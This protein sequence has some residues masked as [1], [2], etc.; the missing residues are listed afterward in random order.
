MKV[1][2]AIHASVPAQLSPTAQALLEPVPGNAPG[3]P[4]LED[5]PAFMALGTDAQ[6]RPERCIGDDTIPAETPNWIDIQTRAEAL[7]A[8]SKDVRIALIWL[9]AVT[10]LEG[11]EGYEAGLTFVRELAV[12]FWDTLHPRLEPSASE[13]GGFDASYRQNMFAELAGP[14]LM[15]A[16]RDMP[17]VRKRG[18]V[19]TLRDIEQAG[20]GKLPEKALAEQRKQLDDA[21]AEKTP[22]LD[23]ALRLP[24]AVRAL[25]DALTALFGDQPAPRL[26]PLAQL[27]QALA[28]AVG[29]AY[30][31]AAGK[32]AAAAGEALGAPSSDVREAASPP[33]IQ[34]ASA[35][36]LSGELGSRAD[37]I[38]WLAAVSAFIE[39]TEPAHPAPLL[40]RRASALLGM[41]FISVMRELAPDSLHQIYAIAGIR[42]E[43][44]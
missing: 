29:D 19:P 38:A 32:A 10:A 31:R 23:V 13:P 24:G 43:A 22:G 2:E 15:H 3:G 40:I 12:R 33:A 11:L 8:R 28:Q 44:R 41:D 17:V 7:L 20:R 35:R 25:D 16:L 18:P 9:R 14:V 6:G 5:E 1:S 26:A 34:P 39:R 36:P 21:V 4:N 37:A 42:P 27:M 30:A